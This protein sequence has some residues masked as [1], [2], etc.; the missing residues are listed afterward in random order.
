MTTPTWPNIDKAHIV[1]YGLLQQASNLK[2]QVVATQSIRQSQ[3]L[4]SQ[5]I[6]ELGLAETVH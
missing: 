2:M 6:H 1:Q 4:Q 3:P 5:D